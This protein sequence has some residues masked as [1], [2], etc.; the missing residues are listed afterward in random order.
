MK[1]DRGSFRMLQREQLLQEL[2]H[3]SYKPK[4][5]PAGPAH[6]PECGAVFR[7]GRWSWGSADPGAREERGPACRRIRE[8]MPAGYVSLRGGFF[9][10]HREEI[11]AR[12]RH[13]EDGQR[14]EHPL[15]R[16]MALEDAEDGMLVT[17]TDIHLA[18]RIGEALHD[19]YKGELE[20]HYNKEQ[21]LLRVAWSR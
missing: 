16:I 15:E 5:K 17:T 2:V 10:A 19:A 3:D 20:F 12:V 18:R 1:R 4:R 21:N 14:R 9:E 13:C 7:G 6:C 8:R 11:L